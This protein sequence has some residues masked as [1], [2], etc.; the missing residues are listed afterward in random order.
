MTKTVITIEGTET[1]GHIYAHLGVLMDQ[2]VRVMKEHDIHPRNE[3]VEAAR[4]I[5]IAKLSE[6][7]YSDV[8]YGSHSV[9]ITEIIPQAK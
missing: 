9:E 1:L 5:G 7:L 6:L 8:G 4:N 2:I 3:L